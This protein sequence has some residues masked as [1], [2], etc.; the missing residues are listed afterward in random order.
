[1]QSITVESLVEDRTGQLKSAKQLLKEGL[2]P[3][4]PE[5]GCV[6]FEKTESKGILLL[7]RDVACLGKVVKVFCKSFF[8]KNAVVVFCY[9]SI[10]GAKK[11]LVLPVEAFKK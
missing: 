4:I 10:T 3:F 7:A 8:Y 6:I 5:E 9:D 11:S 1:M 2:L